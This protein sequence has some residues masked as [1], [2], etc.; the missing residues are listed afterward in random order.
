MIQKS[1]KFIIIFSAFLFLA[2][3]SSKKQH[4]SEYLNASKAEILKITESTTEVQKNIEKE[5]FTHKDIKET[6]IK[7]DSLIIVTPEG[8]KKSYYG[9]GKTDKKDNSTETEKEKDTSK[10]QSKSKGTENSKIDQTT[11]A[12][13]KVTDK[14]PDK[15]FNTSLKWL[16]A[17][18]LIGTVIFIVVKFKK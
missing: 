15:S 3:G 9:L 17:L 8:T 6:V 5:K 12:K 2:C 4:I 13:E 10:E 16:A 7:A 14:Q 18:A 1:N 11:K